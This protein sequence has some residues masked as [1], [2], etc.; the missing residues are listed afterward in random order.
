ME[1][2]STEKETGGEDILILHCWEE[3]CRPERE[4]EMKKVTIRMRQSKGMARDELKEQ[5]CPEQGFSP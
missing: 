3:V 2:C 1:V 5:R 4:A